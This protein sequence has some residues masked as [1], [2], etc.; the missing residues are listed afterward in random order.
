MPIPD[1]NRERFCLD[2]NL[3]LLPSVRRFWSGFA[4]LPAVRI[5]LAKNEVLWAIYEERG[6]ISGVTVHS[7]ARRAIPA[8]DLTG[9]GR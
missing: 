8:L 7:A 9:Y 3:L 6:F 5:R 1:A 4:C 2:V